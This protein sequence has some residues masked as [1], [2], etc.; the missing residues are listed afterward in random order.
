MEYGCVSTSLRKVLEEIFKNDM[1]SIEKVALV[2]CNSSQNLW[3]IYVYADIF[4]GFF[5]KSTK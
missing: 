1:T 5:Q 4:I 3:T 2:F